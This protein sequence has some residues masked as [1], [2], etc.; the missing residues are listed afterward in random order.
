VLTRAAW[1]I[2]AV[3]ATIGGTAA[4][5]YNDEPAEPNEVRIIAVEG[6]EDMPFAFDPIELTVEAGTTVRWRNM[7]DEVFHTV[8]FTNSLDSRVANGV[9]DQSVFARGDVVE[10]R[11]DQPGTYHYFCQPHSTF[12]AGTIVVTEPDESRWAR[13]AV[14]AGATVV[15]ATSGWAIW[16]RQRRHR[17]TR[18]STY[19]VDR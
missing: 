4:T 19:G 12:M 14:S 16:R 8:T 18:E 11:F 13:L 3:A 1:A 6:N 17:V 2:P 9:F 10:Y 5:A 7:T 15:V